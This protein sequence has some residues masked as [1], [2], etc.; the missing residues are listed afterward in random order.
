MAEQEQQP[1]KPTST[2]VPKEGDLLTEGQ[3]R[4]LGTV[5]RRLELAV[6]Q[7]EEMLMRENPLDL[8]LT[9]V[10]NMP[11]TL[12]LDALFRLAQCIQQEIS[13]LAADYGIT[14]EEEKQLHTLSAQFTL[15]WADLEDVNPDHLRSYGPVHPRLHEQLGPQVQRLAHLTLALADVANGTRDP[16]AV[17]SLVE[18]YTNTSHLHLLETAGERSNGV[19]HFDDKEE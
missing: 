12:Q 6:W 16:N 15:L 14:S 4:R 10:T 17:R 5:L 1:E 7:M 18:E 2:V 11:D 9:H 3:R 13:S 19:P 8:T